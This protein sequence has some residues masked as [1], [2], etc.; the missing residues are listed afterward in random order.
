MSN[1]P[2]MLDELRRLLEEAGLT[3]EEANLAVGFAIAEAIHIAEDHHPDAPSLLDRKAVT[4]RIAKAVESRMPGD[5]GFLRHFLRKTIRGLALREI[6]IGVLGNAMFFAISEVIE[7]LEKNGWFLW[8]GNPPDGHVISILEM[9]YDEMY[10]S[11]LPPANHEELYEVHGAFV[12]II[13]LAECFEARLIAGGP[14]Y[15]VRVAT[16]TNQDIDTLIAE[17][18]R[19]AAERELGNIRIFYLGHDYNYPAAFW[20]NHGARE[21]Q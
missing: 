15:W 5:T 9:P 21:K 8:S 10:R 19:T 14:P 12:N 7:Y 1:A 16:A 13:K 20:G 3:P 17:I 18:T 6:L 11:R 2:S 4:P